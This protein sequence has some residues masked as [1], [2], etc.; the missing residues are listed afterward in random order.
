M[1]MVALMGKE[2]AVLMGMEGVVLAKVTYKVHKT[3]IFLAHMMNH[4]GEKAFTS[5][6]SVNRTNEITNI[7]IC[8]VFILFLLSKINYYSENVINMTVKCCCYLFH[9]M[10]RAKRKQFL[11]F[12]CDY[13]SYKLYTEIYHLGQNMLKYINCENRRIL[14][15]EDYHTWKKLLSCSECDFRYF[16]FYKSDHIGEKLLICNL[17]E[18]KRNLVYEMLHTG[19]KPFSC[20]LV[21]TGN[22]GF[23][24]NINKNVLYIQIILHTRENPF[25]WFRCDSG[26]YLLFYIEIRVLYN[27]GNFS[28]MYITCTFILE[29]GTLRTLYSLQRV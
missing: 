20:Q 16:Q 8:C 15:Y 9:I 14:S 11:C 4:T 21:K 26:S 7:Y 5:D 25:C 12:D 18:N 24:F 6:R 1:E 10:F 22:N 2:E 3:N 17:C 28:E 23:I 13:R 19:K 27:E 29:N